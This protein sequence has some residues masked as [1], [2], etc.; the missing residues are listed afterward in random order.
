MFY[1][2]VFL[3]FSTV[4]PWWGTFFSKQHRPRAET[5][6]QVDDWSSR[7]VH[8]S[9]WCWVIRYL[10]VSNTTQDWVILKTQKHKY[11]FQSTYKCTCLSKTTQFTVNLEIS[12]RWFW[13]M[14]QWCQNNFS[15]IFIVQM[16]AKRFCITYLSF[17]HSCTCVL[18]FVVNIHSAYLHMTFLGLILM[19]FKNG[20]NTDFLNQGMSMQEL[21]EFC[22]LYMNVKTFLCTG[23]YW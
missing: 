16:F 18:W 4:L 12:D 15:S 13:V 19:T 7:W 17:R 20:S 23:S 11:C 22:V 2:D 3:L 5:L 6:V 10:I 21:T 9:T 1:V 8:E 14:I